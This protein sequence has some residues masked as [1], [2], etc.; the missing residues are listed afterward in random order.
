MKLFK[1]HYICCSILSL[2]SHRFVL[3]TDMHVINSC[4]GC[5]VFSSN[6]IDV[7]HQLI[8]E[9]Q[10][11]TGDASIYH[12]LIDKGQ[13]YRAFIPG[14]ATTRIRFHRTYGIPPL[15]IGAPGKDDTFIS[16]DDTAESWQRLVNNVYTGT[17]MAP[18]ARGTQR[19]ANEVESSRVGLLALW[20]FGADT[21]LPYP[22]SCQ[23][24]ATVVRLYC[25]LLPECNFHAKFI[26]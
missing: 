24:P 7:F 22:Q 13:G 4:Y 9:S 14:P 21:S 15:L 5:S 8:C 2:S 26:G 18:M 1:H 19:H 23:P 10:C 25:I 11:S 16:D 3:A 17:S 20:E 12:F 6:D